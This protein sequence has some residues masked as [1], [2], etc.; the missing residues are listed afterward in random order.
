LGGVLTLFAASHAYVRGVL[1]PV[2]SMWDGHL[3]SAR[4]RHR[5]SAMDLKPGDWVEI[6]GPESIRR[7][8]DPSGRRDGLP[9]MPEM[10]H[11]CG[12]RFRLSSQVRK[13]CVEC[14]ISGRTIIDIR[15]FRGNEPIWVIENLRCTGAAHD[16]CERGCL[17]FWKSSW[18]TKVPSKSQPQEP[19][20]SE[21]EAHSLLASLKTKK[22][23]ET[24]LC[25]STELELVCETMLCQRPI[26]QDSV[27]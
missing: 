16:G 1:L 7:T 6:N 15:E 9:F 13:S 11:Y 19:K 14:R 21:A 20:L 10:V 5:F 4:V 8:L 23:P 25:Q 17:L 22:A 18:L 12:K 3:K 24:Y 26:E 27:D 2:T